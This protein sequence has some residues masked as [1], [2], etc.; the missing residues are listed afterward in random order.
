MP[1]LHPAVDRLPE[2][3]VT[4]ETAD[5]EV[6]VVVRVAADDA[7][8]RRGLMEVADLPPGYGMLF[9]FDDDRDGGFWMWNTLTDLDI[10]FAD[11][12]GEVHTVATM[13][14]CD[15]EDPADCP[16]TTPDASYRTALEVP[17]GWFEE[18]GVTPGARLAWRDLTDRDR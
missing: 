3:V 5:D 4:L 18:V 14:P 7:S 1:P 8:R 11:E 13:T 2:A 9:V 6:E 12:A 17:G 15:A 16:V 10:A